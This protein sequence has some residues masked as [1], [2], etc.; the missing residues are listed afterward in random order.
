MTSAPIA[1]SEPA[2]FHLGYRPS[3]DGLRGVAVLVVMAHHAYIPCF[4]GGA[5]GV[6][7]FFVLSG[8][9][10][11]SLLL[12][13]WRAT[14]HISL[15]AF[16]IRRGLRLLPALFAFLLCIQA[17]TLL[18]MRGPDFWQMEKA[19]LAVLSYAGNW[20]RA[21]GLLDMRVLSHTWSLS[22]EEQF[23]LLWPLLLLVMLR[24]R[25]SSGWIF[26]ALLLAIAILAV[27]RGLM[28]GAVPESRIYNGSDTRFDE[29]LTGCALAVALEAGFLRSRLVSGLGYLLL[30]AIALV[31]GLIARPTTW[32]RMG[33]VG[34]PA[35]EIS[36]MLVMLYLVTHS[37][38]TLHRLLEARWLV[39]VGRIS[40]GLYLW[41][42][43]LIDKAGGW[44]L[45]GPVKTAVGIALTF[46]VAA[47][48][49][50]VIERP[51]LRRK[52]KLQPAMA[53]AQAA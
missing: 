8:F 28:V 39:W 9:L 23:Y 26:G 53:T 24:S 29:L 27:R 22:I 21:F 17:Y 35:V 36:V 30:P 51:F 18:F 6:D 46:A 3:L 7:I 48:S 49:F 5:V 14:Q 38:T 1:G 43:P 52:A 25:R 10:I 12:E 44:R 31:L 45:L 15:R 34:W 47:V 50:R 16:Y 11:S 40:Y 2:P 32:P 42:V 13:E 19:S 37:G 33:R 4:R 41:H 20:V